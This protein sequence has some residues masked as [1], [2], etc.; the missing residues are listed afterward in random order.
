MHLRTLWEPE[1]P[2]G[3]HSEQQHISYCY[4]I[5]FHDFADNSQEQMKHQMTAELNPNTA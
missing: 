5:K 3:T 2:L 1:N 4:L